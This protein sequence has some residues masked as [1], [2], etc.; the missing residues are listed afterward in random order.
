MKSKAAALLLLACVNTAAIAKPIKLQCAFYD[1]VKQDMTFEL[2]SQ[3]S[4]VVDNE[5]RT[6]REN[7]VLLPSEWSE[8]RLTI[9]EADVKNTDPNLTGK[10][11]TMIDRSDGKLTQNPKRHNRAGIQVKLERS[12]IRIGQ[13]SEPKTMF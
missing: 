10:L 12:D 11:Y 8:D 5:A 9:E 7:G 6:V 13:C 3:R 1:L 4:F 2:F